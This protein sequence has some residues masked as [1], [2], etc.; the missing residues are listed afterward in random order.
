MGT[1]CK[2][3]LPSSS[4]VL[5]KWHYQAFSIYIPLA[6]DPWFYAIVGK[7]KMVEIGHF[8]FEKEIKDSI[9]KAMCLFLIIQKVS[10]LFLLCLM[11]VFCNKPQ[12]Q[13]KFGFDPINWC[14]IVNLETN[15]YTLCYEC[16]WIFWNNA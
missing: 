4:T 12:R 3:F 5:K 6:S 7:K 13:W 8:L 9:N 10:V 15:L 1:V 11:T 16:N 14:L 2:C